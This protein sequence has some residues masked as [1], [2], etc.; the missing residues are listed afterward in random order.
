MS[1]NEDEPPLFALSPE[2]LAAGTATPLAEARNRRSARIL[3]ALPLLSTLPA[4]AAGWAA[5]FLCLLP[6]LVFAWWLLRRQGGVFRRR[7]GLWTRSF[8]AES[9]AFLVAEIPH[10]R[11]LDGAG[12]ELFRQRAKIFL[13]ETAFHGAGVEVDEGLRLRAA[14]AAVIPT[15]GFPEWQWSGL[16][17]VIFRPE[18]YADG[19]YVGDDGVVTE[20]EESGLVGMSGVLSGVMMLSSVDLAWEFAHPEDGANVGFHEFAHLM[21]AGGGLLAER[22]REGWDKLLE[23]ERRRITRRESLL[24][25]YA[26]LNGDELFAV[27]S[28]LF[29]TLPHLFRLWHRELYAVL[30]RAYR[31]DPCRW[32]E[33]CGPPPEPPRR[34]RRR[35]GRR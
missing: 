24:D 23:R 6:A 30:G 3:A 26:L 8:P 33:D 28:E 4:A 21:A 5:F 18:G 22:D 14:A 27:A 35:A 15:L 1:T 12:R 16:R 32:L 9:E 17:E 11:R 31:Q 10:Y 20:F 29:F 7:R 2:C 25:E 13:A 34:R 19:S